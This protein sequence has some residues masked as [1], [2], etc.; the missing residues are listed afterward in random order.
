VEG[1]VRRATMDLDGL[2]KYKNCCRSWIG[3]CVSSLMSRHRQT[4]DPGGRSMGHRTRSRL[5]VLVVL[6][7]DVATIKRQ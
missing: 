7:L 3:H 5:D 4:R 6:L 2:E 1:S